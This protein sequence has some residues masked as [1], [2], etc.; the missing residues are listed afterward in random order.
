MRRRLTTL[1][2]HDHRI[3][4]FHSLSST[5]SAT[6]TTVAAMDG[7]FGSRPAAPAIDNANAQEG[8]DLFAQ[9]IAGRFNNPDK[10]L[11]TARLTPSNLPSDSPRKGP[12]DAG[13][14]VP[15]P[16]ASSSSSRPPMTLNFPAPRRPV[17]QTASSSSSVVPTTASSNFNT[18]T[19][20]M[21]QEILKTPNALIVDV[22]PH[23]A[24]DTSRLPHAVS[25]SVP[26]TLLKRPKFSLNQLALMLSSASARSRI[27]NW[28]KASRILLYDA[29]SSTLQEGSNILG[30]MRKFRDGGFKGD[31]AWLQG[32]IQSLWRDHRHLVDCDPVSEDEDE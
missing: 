5:S 6:A 10:P 31:I 2:D 21:V 25:L 23:S 27:Q 7:F 20:S 30:L 29:D 14:Q 9:A 22:R 19:A 3:P 18:A 1:H 11:L 26:S 8:V 24:Y 4:P 17:P 32:G 13:S 28:D 12:H 15:T 16:M